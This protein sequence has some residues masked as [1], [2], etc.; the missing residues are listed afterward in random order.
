MYLERR[1]LTVNNSVKERG[2]YVCQCGVQ[3]LPE[4]FCIELS[5]GTK[6]LRLELVL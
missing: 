4:W 5:A 3:A 6:R 2:E 1:K